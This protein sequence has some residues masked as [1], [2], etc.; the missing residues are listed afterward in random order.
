MIIRNRY[1]IKETN[2]KRIVLILMI[3]ITCLLHGITMK[4]QTIDVSKI[5]KSIV[6][7]EFPTR[8]FNVLDYGATKDGITDS[9]IAINKAI[10]ACSNAQGGIVLV[11]VGTYYLAGS[12]VMKSNVNLKVEE[13]AEIVFSSSPKDYM[14]FVLTVWEG[15][16]LFNYSPLVYGYHVSNIAITGK[17][18]HRGLKF[19]AVYVKWALTRFRYSN[20]ILGLNPSFH[21][22]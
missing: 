1:S 4:A 18:G 19:K 9:R 21:P 12:I 2:M 6:A 20:V 13:G 8:I 5:L 15:T 3:S 7:P 16:E 17:G 14:P 10:T 11:P 22:V